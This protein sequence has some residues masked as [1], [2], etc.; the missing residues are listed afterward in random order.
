MDGVRIRRAGARARRAQ[1]SFR[2]VV[3]TVAGVVFLLPL[4][5]LAEFS[6]RYPLTG[7]VDFGAWT[8]LFSADDSGRLDLLKD[9]L[10]NSLIMCAMTVVLAVGLLLPTMVLVRLRLPGLNRVIEFICL[11]PLTIPAV[12]LV[13]GLAP[14]YAVIST[15]I[16]DASTIW[17]AFAYVIL[18]LPYAYR[19]LDA[20]LR[21]IDLKTLSESARSLGAS[22]ATILMRI[23]VPNVRTSI[24]SACFITIAVVLGEFTFARMLARNN[25]QT[26]LFQINLSD[27]QVAAVVSVVLI[28]VTT[29]MLV[30][31]DL[32]AGLNERRRGFGVPADEAA[33]VAP[34][35]TPTREVVE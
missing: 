6:I 5:S 16:L 15:R 21:A 11:L 24:V 12:V 4:V 19:A 22:W 3:L 1:T 14:I 7:K 9:G 35:P 27:G 20:G 32:V 30:A 2:V 13:V 26:A 23:I 29:L 34:I 17:L 10:M 28:A 33:L 31:L 8:S 18:V 25:L